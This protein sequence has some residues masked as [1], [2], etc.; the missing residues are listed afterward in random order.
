MPATTQQLAATATRLGRI[1]S[2]VLALLVYGA[3][4]TSTRAENNS[5]QQQEQE[6]E[7]TLGAAASRETRTRLELAGLSHSSDLA[8]PRR[9][10]AGRSSAAATTADLIASR[11]TVGS[12]LPLRL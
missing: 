3:V 10:L 6:Q 4:P 12:S 2:L 7:E 9:Q 5:N 8:S 1:V 11:P